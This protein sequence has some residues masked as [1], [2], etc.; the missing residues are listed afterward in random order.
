[1]PGFGYM[2]FEIDSTNNRQLAV[3]FFLYG[4]IKNRK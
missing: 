4:F 1:M 2:C 3:R